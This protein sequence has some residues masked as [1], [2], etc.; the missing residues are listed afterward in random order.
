[1]SQRLYYDDAYTTRF[2]AR[3]VERLDVRGQP[4]IILD[5]TYFYPDSGGQPADT[6]Q[7]GGADLVA[8]RIRES[9]AAIIHVLSHA[10]PGDQVQCQIDWTRRFDH[11]QHHTGQHILTQAFVLVAGANT[12]GFHLS[13][14][15]VTIDLDQL[16]ITD[17]VVH[18]AEELANQIVIENRPVTARLIQPD[19]AARVRIRKAPDHLATQGL[20]VIDIQDYDLTACGGTHVARTGEI[21]LIKI[22]RLEKRG[23]RTRVEFRCGWRALRDYQAKHAIVAQL[24]SDL[25]CGVSELPE[26]VSRLQQESRAAQRTIKM[27]RERLIDEEAQRLLNSAHPEGSVRWIEAVFTNRDAGEIRLLG[28]RLTRS[29]Q[30]LALLA[31]SGDK[32]H[33]VLARSAD[34]DL[35]LNSALKAALAALGGGKGGGPPD[36]VQGGGIPADEEKV[37]AA[38]R[39]A[40]ASLLHPR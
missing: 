9:D 35:D 37:A 6:G 31:T 2:E 21:G 16:G 28:A 29:A 33:L 34:L 12:V 11:M 27:L 22:L 3:I 20:R 14:D 32:A 18:R 15:S 8:L 36:M 10:P 24:V 19:E 1:M 38:L 26:A 5:R 40:R 4:G 17:A 39:A 13:P 7:I 23:D 30:V 25:T